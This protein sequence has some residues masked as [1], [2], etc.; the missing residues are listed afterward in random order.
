MG[1]NRDRK[2]RREITAQ[3]AEQRLETFGDEF[4]NV[5]AGHFRKNRNPRRETEEEYNA[6]KRDDQKRRQKNREN[7][8]NAKK[9]WRKWII[10]I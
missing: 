6:R 10:C 4:L 3:I 8:R 1:K 2:K 5:N 7:Q 9:A